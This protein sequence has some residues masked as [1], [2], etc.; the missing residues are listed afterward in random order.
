MESFISALLENSNTAILYV[1]SHKI[2]HAQVDE[3]SL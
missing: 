1:T 3:T 2:T